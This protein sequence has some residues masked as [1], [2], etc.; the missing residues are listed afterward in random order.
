DAAKPIVLKVDP[1]SGKTLW[2]SEQYAEGCFL[3]GKYL[4]MTDAARAG[5]GMANAVEDAFGVASRSAG[6]VNIYRIDPSNG[7]QL[8]SFSKK[9]APS[10]IDFSGNRL[11]L[12][13]SDEIDVMKF[14]S[15]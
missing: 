13:Y 6:I 3:T 8:W 5:F 10:D 14:L 9:G 15:F 4:Y 7:K 12:H 2:K 11:L 1:K